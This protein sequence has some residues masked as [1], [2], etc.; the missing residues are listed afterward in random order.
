[1]TPWY[2]AVSRIFANEGV[3]ISDWTAIAKTESGLN[4]AKINY[5]DP[6]G[7]SYGLFQ[8]NLGGEGFA[9]RNNPQAL[10]NPITNAKIASPTIAKAYKQGYA[11]GFRGA[12]L[13]EYTATHSGHP[14]FAPAGSI[15]P[16]TTWTSYGSFLREANLV[17]SN[18]ASLTR[19]SY[20]TVGLYHL[21]SSVPSITASIEKTYTTGQASASSPSPWINILHQINT[22]DTFH[23][24]F[25]APSKSLEQDA[26]TIIFKLGIVVMALAIALI[27]LMLLV[28]TDN[29]KKMIR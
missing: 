2:T 27:G 19:T 9:Y 21:G 26:G 28:G 18:Y 7:G 17:G 5:A 29:L 10:L 13:A 15:L 22:W 25:W 1:M 4:P 20:P 8:E 6:N 14:G 12:Q 24:S 3:P 11:E 16:P 23:W